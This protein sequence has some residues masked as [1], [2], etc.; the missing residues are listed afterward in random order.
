MKPILL[1]DRTHTVITHKTLV[2]LKGL[3]GWCQQGIRLH[4]VVQH[5]HIALMHLDYMGNLL[6]IAG[7][8]VQRQGVT[9]KP[10]AA[11]AFCYNS[12]LYL[13]SHQTLCPI[14]STG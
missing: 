6:P 2:H 4:H 13:Y 9:R 14:H 10:S 1:Y 7:T 11:K 12:M 8:R 3:W 5:T